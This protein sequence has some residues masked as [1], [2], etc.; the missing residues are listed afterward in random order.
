LLTSFLTAG[1]TASD[2]GKATITPT[3]KPNPQ[4]LRKLGLNPKFMIAIA[5]DIVKDMAID[6][7]NANSTEEYF[8]LI[9][10]AIRS[11]RSLESQTNMA[12]T[13]LA[14]L[15]PNRLSFISIFWR[16]CVYKACE[17]GFVQ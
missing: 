12:E 11:S 13:K 3:A 15:L 14:I 17:T 5:S 16:N 7:N 2:V 1:I 4:A 9:F 6:M 8:L 10:K